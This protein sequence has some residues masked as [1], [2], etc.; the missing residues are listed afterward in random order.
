MLCVNI[1][2]HKFVQNRRASAGGPPLSGFF[3]NEET[4][5]INSHACLDVFSLSIKNQI[6]PNNLTNSWLE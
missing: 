5:R 1:T 4:V 6:R 3:R 2:D